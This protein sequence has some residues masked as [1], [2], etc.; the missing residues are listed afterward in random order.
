MGLC[1]IARRDSNVL[2]HHVTKCVPIFGCVPQYG[3]TNDSVIILEHVFL[4]NGHD[5]RL[6]Q[7]QRATPHVQEIG[8]REGAR[9]VEDQAGGSLLLIPKP[10][11]CLA[12]AVVQNPCLYIAVAD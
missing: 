5:P 7:A 2:H 10:G 12:A 8:H 6:R 3:S 9:G 4:G 11:G 1:L